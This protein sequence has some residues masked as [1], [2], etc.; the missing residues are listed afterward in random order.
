[1]RCR[2]RSGYPLRGAAGSCL[3]VGFKTHRGPGA[4]TDGQLRMR[5]AKHS[6]ALGQEVH[7][8]VSRSRRKPEEKTATSRKGPES[9]K[10][11]EK[12]IAI[13]HEMKATEDFEETAERLFTMV[14]DAAHRFPGAPRKLLLDIEGHRNGLGAFDDDAYELQRHFVL[15]FL[16][17]FL[18]GVSIPLL[19]ATNNQPQRDDVPHRLDIFDESMR[20]EVNARAVALGLAVYD[21]DAK[22]TEATDERNRNE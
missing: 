15:G 18:S 6:A 5:H 2:G 21:A 16:M 10:I 4:G 17:P 1:M 9:G 13:Y 20:D 19:Q 8:S 7:L 11:S 22:E 14:R 12:G 3:N